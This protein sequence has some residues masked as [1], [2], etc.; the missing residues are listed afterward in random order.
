MSEKRLIDANALLDFIHNGQGK[1]WFNSTSNRLTASDCVNAQPTVDA[2]AV[3]RCGDCA[4]ARPLCQSEFKYC[5]YWQPHDGETTYYLEDDGFC[6][7][8]ERKEVPDGR[9]D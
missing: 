1:E 9:S 8:G 7:Y 4:W 3:V 5:K 2:V 6:K